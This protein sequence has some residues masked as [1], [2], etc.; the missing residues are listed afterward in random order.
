M[1]LACE[2]ELIDELLGV[3]ADAS[4]GLHGKGN[5]MGELSGSDVLVLELLV[6][7]CASGDGEWLSTG[8]R[9]IRGTERVRYDDV[10]ENAGAWE[11]DLKVG[12][13]SI[14]SAE[15]LRLLA[16]RGS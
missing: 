13:A 12:S 6:V 4:G 15:S 7:G 11:N 1:V 14:F 8:E 2:A 10:G 16:G 9:H 5:E 3:T